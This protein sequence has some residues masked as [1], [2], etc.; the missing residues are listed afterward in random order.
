MGQEHRAFRMR[1]E[2]KRMEINLHGTNAPPRGHL[3]KER[4]II[5]V[6]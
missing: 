5:R 2:G 4:L 3:L 6:I 1:G